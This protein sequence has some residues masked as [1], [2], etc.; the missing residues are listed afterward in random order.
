MSGNVTA[1]VI[2]SPHMANGA[3]Y[4]VNGWYRV[5]LQILKL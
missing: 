1:L 3:G 5:W 2:L 4:S